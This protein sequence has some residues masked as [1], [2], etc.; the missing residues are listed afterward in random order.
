VL[1][2]MFAGVA[3]SLAQIGIY[4]VMA[5]SVAQR[6][7]EIGI[8][9][10]LGAQRSEVMKL[11]LAESFIMTFAGVTLGLGGAAALTGYLG[12]ACRTTPTETDET[13]LPA[14]LGS[15]LARPFK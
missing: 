6:T 10:A 8:R 11:V 3:V 7:R 13:A 15:V 2:G 14:R 1:I 9:M 4:G 12:G 5:H